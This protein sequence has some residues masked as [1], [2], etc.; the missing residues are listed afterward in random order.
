M[1]LSQPLIQEDLLTL[2]ALT[3]WISISAPLTQSL[4]PVA[5]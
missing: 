2:A 3:A 4:S 5:L 1:I